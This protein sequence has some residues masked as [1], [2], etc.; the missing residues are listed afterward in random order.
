MDTTAITHFF[1]AGRQEV[2]RRLCPE[3]IIVVPDIVLLEA[4]VATDLG[5]EVPDLNDIPWVELW[6]LSGEAAKY[7][8]EFARVMGADPTPGGADGGECAVLGL[9]VAQGM[10]AVVDDGA[11]NVVA[12]SGRVVPE[13]D[14]RHINTMW[15]IAQAYNELDDVD[16]QEAENIYV[17]LR[18]TGMRLPHVE[19]FMRWAR[20][21]ADYITYA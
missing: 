17:D 18:G 8:E 15:I 16:A 5:Y 21:E 3:G 11:A 10:V 9:A 19:S 6:V 1:R 20:E 13:S 4:G 2:L 12:R 7:E 14:L